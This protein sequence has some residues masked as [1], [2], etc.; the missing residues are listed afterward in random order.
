MNR[1]IIKSI[2]D[3]DPPPPT[4]VFP[5]RKNA[6]A[7]LQEVLVHVR[8]VEGG[9]TVLP[10]DGPELDLVAGG[11]AGGGRGAGRA[12]FFPRRGR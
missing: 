1:S 9:A 6:G 2:L 4:Y 10:S 3:L 11:P 7:E 5:P 12:L 8:Q